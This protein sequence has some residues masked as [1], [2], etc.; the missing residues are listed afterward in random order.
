[1]SGKRG[2]RILLRAILFL[3]LVL[4]AGNAIYVFRYAPVQQQAM[5]AEQQLAKP[6]FPPYAEPEEHAAIQQPYAAPGR[7][8]K[9]YPRSTWHSELVSKREDDGSY[10]FNVT[11][12]GGRAGDRTIKSFE[13]WIRKANE[14][15]ESKIDLKRDAEGKIVTKISFPTAGE[16]II[17]VRLARESETLEFSE[18]VDVK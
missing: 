16:W 17:R 14:T 4:A 8:W 1:M 5:Q 6:V 10:S 3:L 11:S 12:T 18:R 15:S 2:N 7:D 13:A 9:Y